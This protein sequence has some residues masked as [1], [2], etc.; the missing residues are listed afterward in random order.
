M[1]DAPKTLTEKLEYLDNLEWQ[2]SKRNRTLFD[3]R[4]S[5]LAPVQEALTNMEAEYAP[6]IDALKDQIATI[7]EQVKFDAVAQF[8]KDGTKETT[9]RMK[10]VRIQQSGTTWDTKGLDAI[11][12]EVPA[13]LRFR[14]EGTFYAKF[15]APKT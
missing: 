8:E 13:I 1:S 6:E 9:T 2:L 10:L 5:I 11:A 15:G 3:T 7:T 12:S 14:R 4:E